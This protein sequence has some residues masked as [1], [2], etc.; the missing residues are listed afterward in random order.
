MQDNVQVYYGPETTSSQGRL[1][2]WSCCD[3][4]VGVYS[5]TYT[6]SLRSEPIA[7]WRSHL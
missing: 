1:R 7:D 6:L 5:Y 4:A 3:H 2:H